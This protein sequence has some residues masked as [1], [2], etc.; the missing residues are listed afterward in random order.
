M[1]FQLQSPVFKHDERIPDQYTC[2][3][4]EISPPL[5]WN[6]APKGTQSFALLMEDL[7]VPFGT[8][9]HW[10]IFNIPATQHELAEAIPREK[11]LPNGIIQGRIFMRRTGYMGPCPL[12]G[13]HRYRFILYALDTLLPPNP[14]INKKAL[15]KAMKGHIL[16]QSELACIYSKKKP[17]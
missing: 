17:E 8:I 1:E 11:L 5:N 2:M 16:A 9:T 3:G 7:D 6:N 4:D 12:W 14:K 10:V 13:T 15:L